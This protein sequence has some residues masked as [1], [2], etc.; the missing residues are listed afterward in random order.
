MIFAIL[1]IFCKIATE[2]RQSVADRAFRS[3]S[4]IPQLFY[5][6]S[7]FQVSSKGKTH[8][9]RFLTSSTSFVAL[10]KV[11]AKISKWLC[12]WKPKPRGRVLP[13]HRLYSCLQQK[14]AAFNKSFNSNRN[15]KDNNPSLSQVLLCNFIINM[16]WETKQC[17]LDLS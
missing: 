17:W 12:T 15:G 6:L 13:G 9:G 4:R 11:W 10:R 1:T 2:Y 8:M 7:G 14:Y 3:W 5:S 16:T